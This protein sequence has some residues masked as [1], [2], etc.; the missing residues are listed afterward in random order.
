MDLLTVLTQ[1]SVPTDFTLL[2]SLALT[3]SHGQPYTVKTLEEL[4]LGSEDMQQLEAESRAAE[5]TTAS[6]TLTR[7]QA[8]AKLRGMVDEPESADSE[9]AVLVGLLPV[10]LAWAAIYEQSQDALLEPCTNVSIASAQLSEFEAGCGRKRD[11]RQ[12]ALEHYAEAIGVPLFAD[13][14]RDTITRQALPAST[15]A[16][17]DVTTETMLASAVFAQERTAQRAWGADRLFVVVPQPQH[18]PEPPAKQKAKG[19]K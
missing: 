4:E 5:I 19:A 10:P 8:L 11:S 1:C 17:I 16:H 14:V 12:C 6:R 2:L 3:F 15:T 18:D 9:V 13:A 7:A